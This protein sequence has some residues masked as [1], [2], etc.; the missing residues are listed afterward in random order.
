MNDIRLTR[1]GKIVVAIALAALAVAVYWLMLD[2][3]TPEECKVD[4]ASMSAACK[5]LVFS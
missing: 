1:R 2:T 4:T 3:V 5:A